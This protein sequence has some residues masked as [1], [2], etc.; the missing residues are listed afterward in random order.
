MSSNTQMKKIKTSIVQIMPETGNIKFGTGVCIKKNV[1][2]T[3]NHVVR[4]LDEKKSFT[5]LISYDLQNSNPKLIKKIKVKEY[6]ILREEKL[7]FA[8]IIILS[9]DLEIEP[10]PLYSIPEFDLKKVNP[11]G[12]LKQNEPKVSSSSKC[13]LSPIQFNEDFECYELHLDQTDGTYQGFSGGPIVFNNEKVIGF[14]H[15]EF[16]KRGY[17]KKLYASIFLEGH[18]QLLSK[19]DIFLNKEKLK[20]DE[21][22]VFLIEWQISLKEMDNFRVSIIEPE[23][24]RI[25]S[26]DAL[27]R[28]TFTNDKTVQKSNYIL[29]PENYLEKENFL[30]YIIACFEFIKIFGNLEIGIIHIG[31]NSN[32]ENFDKSN[33]IYLLDKLETIFASNEHQDVFQED[34]SVIQEWLKNGIISSNKKFILGAMIGFDKNSKLRLLIHLNFSPSVIDST[35][36]EV[37][38]IYLLKIYE[39]NK[40]TFILPLTSVDFKG[41]ESKIVTRPKKAFEIIK[42][43]I[44]K[45]NLDLKIISILCNEKGI[46]DNN[47]WSWKQSIF[48]KFE[49]LSKKELLDHNS[50]IYIL[51]SNFSR[52]EN[53]DFYPGIS[54]IVTIPLIPL[55]HIDYSNK[56]YPVKYNAYISLSHL[57]KKRLKLRNIRE[58]DWIASDTI[59]NEKIFFQNSIDTN[60]IVH[61]TEPKKDISLHCVLFLNIDLNKNII[62]F[63]P[64]QI[65][66]MERWNLI[67][68]NFKGSPE[69]EWRLDIES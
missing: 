34:N 39:E 59:S 5:I 42:S 36:G 37:N 47:S 17:A 45:N 22:N 32:K 20:K 69:Y 44:Q 43:F 25:D 68:R 67:K 19:N 27:E 12:F 31:I 51:L 18:R 7:D 2:M 41:A 58:F 40:N 66:K 65:L 28:L 64:Y 21:Y 50:N 55:N 49:A 29:S 63:D 4:S 60:T 13:E 15:H 11:F 56:Y 14:I 62:P 26:K 30:E 6:R 1:L 48:E 61:F 10:V 3:A 57:I 35:L 9:P 16:N 54:G 24:D 53:G 46:R 38:F 33:I 52:I 8:L 23:L